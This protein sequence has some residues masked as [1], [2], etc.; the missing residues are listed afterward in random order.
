MF[1]TGEGELCG[2]SGY[3]EADVLTCV[4]LLM[5]RGADVNVYDR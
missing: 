2:S 4:N 3:K 5:D 1:M